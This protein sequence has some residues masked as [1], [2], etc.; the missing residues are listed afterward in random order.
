VISNENILPYQPFSWDMLIDIVAS[1]TFL[2]LSDIIPFSWEN[3]F[4]DSSSYA[5][6]TIILKNMEPSYFETWVVSYTESLI[7]IGFIYDITNGSFVSSNGIY[8]ITIYDTYDLYGYYTVSII[9]IT[10]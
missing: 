2:D 9:R 7:E 10:Y 4:I 5:G 8:S 6:A 3:T 1:Y